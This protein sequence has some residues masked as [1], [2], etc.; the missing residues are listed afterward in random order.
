MAREN[1]GKPGCG[2]PAPPAYRGGMQTNPVQDQPTFRHQEYA[3]PGV[4]PLWDAAP[5]HGGPYLAHLMGHLY[6]PQVHRQLLRAAL[7]GRLQCV[8]SNVGSTRRAH[9]RNSEVLHL[10]EQLS[11]WRRKGFLHSE[12]GGDVLTLVDPHA[13]RI[14][15]LDRDAV[16][17]LDGA[18][19][20]LRWAELGTTALHRQEASALRTFLAVFHG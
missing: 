20:A 4:D 10:K 17:P 18:T 6:I 14:H 15:A 13:L 16:M 2:Q 3:H 9:N 7:P 8:R 12:D 5:A 1:P 19:R 11:Q